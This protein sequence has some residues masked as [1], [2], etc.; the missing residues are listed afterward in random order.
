MAVI[1]LS[2]SS[3]VT[4]HE[5]CTYLQLCTHVKGQHSEYLI[6]LQIIYYDVVGNMT[7]ILLQISCWIQRWKNFENQPTFAKGMPKTRVAD[8]IFNW[9]ENF[10]SERVH[11]TR[12]RGELSPTASISASVVQGSSI[13]PASYLSLIHIWRCRRIERCRSRWSPYH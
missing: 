3:S 9:M 12:F 4:Q 6:W 2:C 1:A 11:C 7:E 5:W 10:F 8:Q 13:G